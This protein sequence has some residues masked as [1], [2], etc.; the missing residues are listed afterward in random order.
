MVKVKQLPILLIRRGVNVEQK[1]D[2]QTTTSLLRTKQQ[3][4]STEGI[5]GNGQGH[6]R[7][8]KTKNVTINF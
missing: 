2:V 6:K 3:R 4:K 1:N 5:R 8:S 7:N